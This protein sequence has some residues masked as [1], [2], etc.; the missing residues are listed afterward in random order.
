MRANVGVAKGDAIVTNFSRK[1]HYRTNTNGKISWVRGHTVSRNDWKLSTGIAI[2]FDPP[3]SLVQPLRQYENYSENHP[4][5]LEPASINIW[6]NR[7]STHNARCPVCGKNVFFYRNDHGS[8]VYFDELGPPWAKH[9]CIAGD[10]LA[11]FLSASTKPELPQPQWQVLGWKPLRSAQIF[12]IAS[13]RYGVSGYSGGAL[14]RFLLDKMATAVVHEI[15]SGD[16]AIWHY[17]SASHEGEPP[18]AGVYTSSDRFY[19][20]NLSSF[21]A[22]TY[23]PLIGSIEYEKNEVLRPSKFDP[24]SVATLSGNRF[25]AEPNATCPDCHQGVYVYRG[26]GSG[27][28]VLDE[29]GP[30][31]S[32][33]VCAIRKSPLQWKQAGWNRLVFSKFGRYGDSGISILGYSKGRSVAL[34]LLDIDEYLAQKLIDAK[35]VYYHYRENGGSELVLGVYMV[36]EPFLQVK[37]VWSDANTHFQ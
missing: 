30:P 1:G 10:R 19:L 17:R 24:A 33:H 27:L 14:L 37:A 26:H 18:Q 20:L 35:V 4:S 12:E 36:G 23:E 25:L 34:N 28:L 22:E 15:K 5:H 8:A 16:Q 7:S 31:W 3:A 13:D 9:P 11:I 32:E 29:E 2:R 21:D 6:S